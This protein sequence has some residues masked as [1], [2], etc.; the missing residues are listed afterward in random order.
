MPS[1]CVI[2]IDVDH[3]EVFLDLILANDSDNAAQ[4]VDHLRPNACSVV[5]L[6]PARLRRLAEATSKLTEVDFAAWIQTFKEPAGRRTE[7]LTI[8]RWITG[9]ANYPDIKVG[10]SVD[11]LLR[12]AAGD[13]D[14][15]GI[16][17]TISQTVFEASDGCYYTLSAEAVLERA[18]RKYVE[19]YFVVP[20]RISERSKP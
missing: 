6:D 18:D 20:K 2:S 9:A 5:S 3:Q 19:E 16:V 11:E 1:Y 13:L 7:P 12:A 15:S 4:I 14:N 8:R 10:G 17:D